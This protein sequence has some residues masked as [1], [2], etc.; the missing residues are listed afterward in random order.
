MAERVSIR[1]VFRRLFEDSVGALGGRSP[2]GR[3]IQK[4]AGDAETRRKLVTSP[5]I[6]LAEAG[7]VLPDELTIEVLE[8]TDK[9]I[10]LVLP[11]L[12]HAGARE[13]EAS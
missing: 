11:P 8:N 12:V 2:Y 13:G 7:V 5:K 4:A 9:V 6:A 1:G 3:L 10:H